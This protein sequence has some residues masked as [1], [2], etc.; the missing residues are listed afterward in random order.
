M[1]MVFNGSSCLQND[2]TIAVL[3]CWHRAKLIRVISLRSLGTQYFL[4]FVVV[5]VVCLFCFVFVFLSVFSPRY[6][7]NYKFIY[8]IIWSRRCITSLSFTSTTVCVGPSIISDFCSLSHPASTPSLCHVMQDAW[9]KIVMILVSK[10]THMVWW[11]MYTVYYAEPEWMQL[12]LPCLP[13]PLAP[14]PLFLT[15][16]M[17]MNQG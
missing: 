16:N 8:W 14:V 11:N 6:N 15:D 10:F 5:V 13:S 4:F 2:H 7:Y 12:E 17:K 9:I 1:K 3:W